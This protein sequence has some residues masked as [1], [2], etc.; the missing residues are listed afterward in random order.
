M[1][2]KLQTNRVVLKSD[3]IQT[4]RNRVR[5]LEQDVK[6]LA[7]SLVGISNFVHKLYETSKQEEGKEVTND[8]TK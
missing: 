7:G 4:L 1:K 8:I 6:L 2:K 5:K 3:K